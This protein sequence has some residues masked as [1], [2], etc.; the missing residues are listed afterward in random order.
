MLA[1]TAIELVHMAT[2]VHDDLIDRAPLRRGRATVWAGHGATIARACGDYLFARAFGE[3]ARTREPAAVRLLAAASLDLARGEALQDAQARRPETPV[4]E[5]LERCRLKTGRLFACACGLGGRL[6]GLAEADC[7]TLERFGDALGIAFQLADDVLDCAGDPA[8]TG[9]A[10][11]TDLL[12]GTVTLPL[13]L[14]A[15]RDDAVAA[16]IRSREVAARDVLGTLARVAATGAVDEARAA[17][18]AEGARASAELAL[19]A[20]AGDTGPLRAIVQRA[21]HRDH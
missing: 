10:L 7:A 14:A 3:L 9:K 19:L 21:I 18:E 8:T 13:L 16:A 11:G 5:Y 17:A 4:A 20:A 1:A 2:L 15:Q 6:G 12:D